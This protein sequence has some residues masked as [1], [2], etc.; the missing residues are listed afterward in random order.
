[1]SLT[2]NLKS[3]GKRTMHTM[4]TCLSNHSSKKS[5]FKALK[6]LEKEKG[7]LNKK[8]K[9]QADAYALNT[10]GS[11]KYAP[12]LYVY[13]AMAG[14]FKEG[15]IPDNYYHQVVIPKIQGD[16]GKISFLKPL[17]NK[18][19]EVPAS[20]DIAYFINGH[21]FS[22]DLKPIAKDA[23]KE[24]AFD[25]GDRIV[26][27]LDQSY[28]GRGV[29]VYNQSSLNVEELE[30]KG[31]G[32]LQMYIEQHPFFD[33]FLADSVANIRMTTVIGRDHTPSLRAC[34][35]RFGRSSETHVKSDSH[36]RVPVALGSGE[37]SNVGYLNNWKTITHHPDSLTSF[38]KKTIP[39]YS[40]CVQLVLELHK[41]LPMVQA[42]GWDLA[43]DKNNRPRLME[44]NGYGNDIKFSEATQGPCF[45]D[46]DW[47]KYS[48]N[49]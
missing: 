16:Y 38:S 36:V 14:H 10:L 17:N 27:K 2:G 47:K 22:P 8:A 19:F 15:W 49:N 5:A 4:H 44:W 20:P 9:K 35:L 18:L 42:I 21:W 7:K 48:F 41:N 30:I 45:I 32:T 13:T 29:F 25:K 46:L 1:M 34:Y 24:L 12:W 23:L 39:S 43:V 26:Y 31:N 33:E 40:N 28:Q 11:K 37:L 3:F 6:H